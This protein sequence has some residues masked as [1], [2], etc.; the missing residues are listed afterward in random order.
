MNNSKCLTCNQNIAILNCKTCSRT[1]CYFCDENLHSQI[2][3]HI[4]TTLIFSTQFSTQSNQNILNETINKKQLE[5]QQLKEK[6][7]KMAKNYQEKIL[8][9]QKQ[10]EHQIN[11]LE[12]RLQLA[13]QCTNKMQDKV[14][15]LDIDKIQKEV[16]N[17]DNSLKIDIQKAAEEQAVLLEKNQKVDQLID[18]LTKATDIEQLQ[19]NK[20]NEVLAVFKECSEQLQKEKEFLMLDNEKLVGEIEIFAKFFDENGPLLEELNKVK[21]EQQQQK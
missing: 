7:Q 10:Y 5:L 15:E 1:M 17:L 4:R 20:M 12:E 13:S 14:E 11:Q 18:R 6:E 16:E 21:N 3:K 19:V 2:D 9:A 8:Q